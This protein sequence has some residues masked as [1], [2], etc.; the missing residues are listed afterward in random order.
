MLNAMLAAFDKFRTYEILSR[1]DIPTPKS[2]LIKSN[3]T[4]ETYPVV[5]KILNG[6]QGIGVSLL[7]SK[8]DFEVFKANFPAE[9]NILL[10]DFIEESKGTDIRLFVVGNQVVAVS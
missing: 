3:D 10:Q 7:H 8:E 2:R 5:A 4:I 9:K 1:H 6:N